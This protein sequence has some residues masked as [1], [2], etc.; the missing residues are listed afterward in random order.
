MVDVL[1]T[2]YFNVGD[3]MREEMTDVIVR[4]S[5]LERASCVLPLPSMSISRPR[6]LTE[7]TFATNSGLGVHCATP[8][9]HVVLCVK[10]VHGRLLVERSRSFFTLMVRSNMEA[11]ADTTSIFL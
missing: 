11:K 10:T 3:A 1:A 6:Y 9:I 7:P 8:S 5:L 4:A 2:V